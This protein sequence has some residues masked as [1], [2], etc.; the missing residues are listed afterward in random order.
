[1]PSAPGLSMTSSEGPGLASTGGIRRGL[2]AGGSPTEALGN[3]LSKCILLFSI[4]PTTRVPGV[5]EGLWE[6]GVKV[7][8]IL[9]LG[10]RTPGTSLRRGP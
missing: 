8:V 10:P 1:M 5:T 6:Q 3:L 2:G 7:V 4:H 9:R